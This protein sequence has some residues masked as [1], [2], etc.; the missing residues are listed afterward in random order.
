MAAA[1]MIPF[2]QSKK[3][4]ALW[5]NQRQRAAQT[6][7]ILDQEAKDRA[8]QGR[9][10]GEGYRPQAD[11]INELV[12]YGYSPEEAAQIIRDQELRE[13]DLTPEEREQRFMQEHERVSARGTPWQ[14]MEAYFTPQWAEQIGEA[15]AARLREQTGRMTGE[16][17]A[18]PDE[19]RAGLRGAIDPVRLRQDPAYR[20]S[21]MAELERTSG[22]VEGAITDP[23][24]QTSERYMGKR[25]YTDKDVAD[26]AE[27]G[28][29]DV[30]LRHQAAIQELE[31]R[32]AAAGSTDP[33][34]LA[35][36]RS[37]LLTQAGVGSADARMNAQLAAM[38]RQKEAE[39]DIEDTRA[40]LAG[41]RAN[42]QSQSRLALGGLRSGM[43]SD[44]ERGRLGAE[45]GYADRAI[46]GAESTADT[47][48]RAALASGQ[49]GRET[50][51]DIRDTAMD[52]ER[53][54]TGTG[55]QYGTL[56]EQ[57]AA[58][59]ARDEARN[60]QATEIEAQEAGY[61]RGL[62]R[63]E[64]LS[65]RSGQ[66]AGTRLQ[67]GAG[68]RSYFGT[69]QDR[70]ADQYAQAMND[71]MRAW[72]TGQQG[73]QDAL[74]GYRQYQAS[75]RGKLGTI[76]AA[77]GIAGQVAGLATGV[78][79]GMGGGISK[80]KS[81]GNYLS[82]GAFEHGGIITEPTM[83]LLGES[84]PEAVVPLS[85]QILPRKPGRVR[86]FLSGFASSPEEAQAVLYGVRPPPKRPQQ[87]YS[88]RR[89]PNDYRSPQMET[90]RITR[91]M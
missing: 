3:E 83:A 66:V 47:A 86:R 10:L 91:P 38:E 1:G 22:G 23:S 5:L 49:A 43:L 32:A 19:L 16:L 33:L 79:A 69:Q 39:Q 84:G 57:Q 48:Y 73:E 60:R 68:A 75:R 62:T 15:G 8:S 74:S 51:A 90:N 78:A 85:S 17:G 65:G 54:K 41:Q 55:L 13:L 24:L 70:A 25:G 81:A 14:P 2:E 4:P 58:Q 67:Q 88:M 34:A 72:Q 7:A 80:P 21:V 31:R 64:L 12:M 89:Q 45:Q 61:G 63:N 6:R 71:R 20:Q 36:A 29:R 76:G 40:G 46:R 18:V 11:Q 26:F 37:R 56:A 9:D 82:G 44:V 50:E 52:V 53:W 87:P 59:R 27:A 30:G 77:L 42:L 35:A 28:A